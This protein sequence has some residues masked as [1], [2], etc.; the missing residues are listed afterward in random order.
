MVQRPGA[1]RARLSVAGDR[2]GRS[3][4]PAARGPEGAG[5]RAPTRRGTVTLALTTLLIALGAYTAGLLGALTGLGGGMVIVP[6]LS[7][8]FGVD[9]RYA[10]GASLVAIIATSSGAAA[11]YV[12]EGYTNLRV[13]MLLEVATTIGALGG[14]WAAGI[15]PARWIAVLFGVVLL[16][17]TFAAPHPEDDAAPLPSSPLAKRLRLSSEYPTPEGPQH[18]PVRNVRAGF[19]LMALAGVLSALLGIGSG[20]VKVLAMDRTMGRPFKGSNTTRNNT[21]RVT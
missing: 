15:I 8:G 9:L 13:G 1:R 14:A 17:T 21:I 6:L 11:A 4:G 18:Y 16:A 19:L 12:R 5:H 2:S 7:I 3:D 20:V 10:I